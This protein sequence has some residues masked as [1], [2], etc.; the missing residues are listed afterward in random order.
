[1]SPEQFAGQVAP[2]VQR[3][4]GGVWQVR[5]VFSPADCAAIV[6][7]AQATGFEPAP[8]QY[9]GRSNEEV[10]LL[11]F[12]AAVPVQSR[13]Q[14]AIPFANWD[15]VMEVYRYKP[16]HYIAPH[17]DRPRP[18]RGGKL[19][20]ATLVVF[21]TQDFDGGYTRFPGLALCARPSP[22]SAVLFSQSLIHEATPVTRGVKVVARMDLAIQGAF[23]GEELAASTRMP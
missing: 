1:M 17:E 8:E 22:G 16:G 19:S 12:P 23:L 3:L 5:D 15:G 18:L 4:Q 13:L 7:S 21:L 2:S 14:A 9:E 20:N 10:F 11:E 6:A